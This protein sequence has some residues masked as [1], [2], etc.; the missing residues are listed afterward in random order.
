MIDIAQILHMEVTFPELFSN[1]K[2]TDYGILFHNTQNPL[3]W[4]SN[5]AQILDLTH[6]E[7]AISDII[8][9]YNSLQLQPRIN[10][11]FLDNELEILRPRLD[12]Q[13]F[14]VTTNNH[15]FMYITP[16]LTSAL[17][18]DAD[19]RRISHISP[20]IVDLLHSDGD[21]DWTVNVLKIMVRNSR[22]HLLGL[23]QDERCVSIA[24]INPGD[25]YTR[26]DDVKTHLAFR[27]KHLGTRLI[28]YLVAY[29]G[30][31]SRNCLYLWAVNPIAIKMYQKSG[32]KEI[33]V[34]KP[35]WT[36]FQPRE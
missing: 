17:E 34:D 33:K 29:H 35:N 28:N 9:F 36:A 18:P 1:K 23:F 32:F 15:V 20:D 16:G 30:S 10:S 8:R 31:I 26:V 25:G 2:S 12:S 11:S 6:P 13:G 4:D 27:G 5:H 22:F 14:T 24:S 21:G 3:S 7:A 19:I